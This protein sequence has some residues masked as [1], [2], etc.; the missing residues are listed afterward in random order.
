MKR[1]LNWQFILG[2]FLIALSALVYFI[3]YLIFRDVHHIMIYLIGDIAFVFFEVLLVTLVLHQ[4]LHYREKRS[5][6]NKLNMVIGA[7]FSEVGIELLKAFSTF[8]KDAFKITQKL[9][10]TNDWSEKEFLK[11]CRS[12]KD[13]SYHIDSKKG[14]LETIKNFLKEKRKFL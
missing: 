10:I 6:L 3:H 12:I 11:I 13:H 9:V 14:D 7:F 5:M 8:D 2:L 1:L 4:L